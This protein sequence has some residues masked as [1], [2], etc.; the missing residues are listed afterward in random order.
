MLLLQANFI[1]RERIN[2]VNEQLQHNTDE[3][4]D[5]Y[6]SCQLK[7]HF[8]NKN[9]H[10]G[11]RRLS[12]DD[13]LFQADGHNVDIVGAPAPK[14]WR[15]GSEKRENTTQTSER[16]DNNSKNAH[17]QLKHFY[18][19]SNHGGPPPLLDAERLFQ[20][21]NHDADVVGAP[22]RKRQLR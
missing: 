12:D 9:K 21:D 13:R 14:R 6:R 1:G 8:M 5:N 4:A 10:G 17:C 3:R 7:S 16:A 18:E 20:V 11:R 15:R 2:K 19:H 22:P